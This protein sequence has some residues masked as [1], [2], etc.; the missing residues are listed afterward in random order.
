MAARRIAPAGLAVALFALGAAFAV[1]L[2]VEAE[3]LLAAADDPV[4]ISDRALSRSFDHTVAATEI[5]AALAAGDADM[6]QSFVALADER[7][8]AVAPDLRNRTR[9]A[10]EAARSAS[11]HAESFARGLITGEP[12]NMVSLAGTALGDLFVFGDLRDVAREGVRYVNGEEVDQ[13]VL[14]LAAV[15]IAVTAGTYA[16]LGAG[17]PA[18]IGLSVAKAA[19]KAGR[20]SDELAAWIGRSLRDVIDWGALKRAGASVAEPA[21]AVRAVR[22]AVKTER[23]G[24]LVRMA[25]DVGRVQTRAGARAAADAMRLARDPADMA[26]IAK[27]ADKKG[28][29]TRAILKTLGRGAIALTVGTFNL[30]SWIFGALLTLFGLVSSAK[31]G[32][33]RMTQRAIDRGKRRRLA[34]HAAMAGMRA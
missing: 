26:R 23:A 18:R 16:T 33:E 11:A 14:G 25:S 24:G 32:V 9:V 17:A 15:G 30:V 5:E 31:S 3:R 19:R 21:V 20:M 10:A 34:R 13:L 4:A 27:L 7:G 28:G 6:A 22:E 2:G 12:D 29:K 1:P 8:V